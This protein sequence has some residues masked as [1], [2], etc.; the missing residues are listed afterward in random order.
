MCQGRRLKVWLELVGPHV[1]A[2]FLSQAEWPW[3]PPGAP[4]AA[5][6]LGPDHSAAGGV[7]GSE[8]HVCLSAQRLLFRPWHVSAPMGM[9]R[10]FVET[11]SEH[12]PAEP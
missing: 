9:V 4:T 3:L 12:F 8:T 6:T 5:C 1:R 10:G 7:G 2:L 11:F